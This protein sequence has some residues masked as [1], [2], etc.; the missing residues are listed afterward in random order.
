MQWQITRVRGHPVYLYMMDYYV[1]IESGHLSSLV[2]LFCEYA[3]RFEDEI[4]HIW[5][6]PVKFSTVLYMICRYIPVGRPVI[7]LLDVHGH[8]LLPPRTSGKANAASLAE[9][10]LGILASFAILEAQNAPSYVDFT[11]LCTV[12]EKQGCSDLLWDWWDSVTCC[13]AVT[14]VS[15]SIQ[16]SLMS[17]SAGLIN[18]AHTLFLDEL[19]GAFLETCV[20]ILASVHAWRSLRLSKSARFEVYGNDEIHAIVHS[21]DLLYLSIITTTW[22]LTLGF[23]Y[24]SYPMVAVIA[25]DFNVPLRASMTARFLLDL[26]KWDHRHTGSS[27]DQQ[28]PALVFAHKRHVLSFETDSERTFR[29]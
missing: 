25:N 28:L 24:S 14:F 19:I 1:W 15:F 9:G 20:F 3:S 21:P 6:L 18:P 16:T 5:T 2:F 10:T 17:F 8:I 29:N 22:I 4:S 23:L 27:T 7:R 13:A 26:R 12:Q 11:D